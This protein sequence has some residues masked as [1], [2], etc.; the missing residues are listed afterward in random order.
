MRS[1][2]RGIRNNNPGN[3]NF[4]YQPGA[5]ME[6]KTALVPN[7]RFAN[8]PTMDDGIAALIHQLTLYFG[9]GINTVAG[10]I[11][12]WAP[13]IENPT[14]AYIAYVARS[15][16]VRPCD[17]LNADAETLAQLACAISHMENGVLPFGEQHA[18]ELAQRVSGV[19]GGAA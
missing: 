19:K 4:A 11:A 12:Q 15:M 5:V 16:H 10:I 17:K 8:F 18:L 1:L 9:R 6:P 13:S 3:L 7:P 14:L 2:P